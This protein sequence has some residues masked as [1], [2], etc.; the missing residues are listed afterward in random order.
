LDKEIDF[1]RIDVE[2]ISKNLATLNKKNGA[3]IIV[4]EIMK[5][6]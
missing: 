4:D 3:K 6:K 2:K 1:D 5:G